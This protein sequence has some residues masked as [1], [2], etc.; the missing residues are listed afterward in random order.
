MNSY[1][2]QQFLDEDYKSC[3]GKIFNL[4]M[5]KLIV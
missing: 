5:E 4:K 2:S 1:L 3:I